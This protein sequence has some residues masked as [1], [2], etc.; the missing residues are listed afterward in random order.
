MT[1]LPK[2]SISLSLAR[3]RP[4]ILATPSPISRTVPTFSFSVAALSPVMRAS[5]S[6]NTV[7]ISFFS[8]KSRCKPG[9]AA[10][11]AAVI[12]V[13][14]DFDAQPADERRVLR[15]RNPQTRPVDL[16]QLIRD[17]LRHFRRDRYGAVH[18]SRAPLDFKFY[19]TLKVR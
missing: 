14:A 10:A 4:S 15:E 1:P 12:H 9:E 5:I 18:A 17:L 16:V 19:Q 2:S 13:A 3:A 11:N 8:S 6:C 7:V